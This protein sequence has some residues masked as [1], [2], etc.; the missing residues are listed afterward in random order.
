MPEPSNIGTFITQT[1]TGWNATGVTGYTPPANLSTHTG[2][3]QTLSNGQTISGYNVT[4]YINVRHDDVTIV[5][6]K[7]VQVR[8][9]TDKRRTKILFCEFGITTGMIEDTWGTT[10]IQGGDYDMRRCK[11]YGAIDQ[12]RPQWG[13]TRCWENWFGPPFSDPVGHQWPPGDPPSRAHCDPCQPHKPPGNVAYDYCLFEANKFDYFP[14]NK[15]QTYLAELNRIQGGNL[16]GDIGGWP[17]TCGTMNVEYGATRNHYFLGNHWDGNCF[18]WLMHQY[19]TDSGSEPKGMVC[20]YNIIKKRW[21]NYGKTAFVNIGG[22]KGNTAIEWGQNLNADTGTVIP[23]QYKGSPNGRVLAIKPRDQYPTVYGPGG[24]GGETGGG[25]GGGGTENP[26]I[27][28]AITSP[29]D[30]STHTS[31]TVVFLGG[32]DAAA[33]DSDANYTFFDYK[34]RYP[35]PANSALTKTAF[36]DHDRNTANTGFTFT[37]TSAG[38][39]FNDRSSVSHTV[40]GPATLVLEGIRNDGTVPSATVDVTFGEEDAPPPA[41]TEIEF[42]ASIT[43]EMEGLVEI[44]S[45]LAGI[46][47]DFVARKSELVPRNYVRVW[48]DYDTR[49]DR[50][51]VLIDGQYVYKGQEQ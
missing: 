25:G 21:P 30:G 6:C 38:T 5:A 39:T 12:T 32:A 24:G 11:L 27:Q 9:N 37:V 40:L 26:V 10:Q 2:N 34:V 47:A 20:G 18:Q 1:N 44:D 45:T 19:Q 28:L 41:A 4:G 15:G 16:T 8:I 36:L 43:A 7:G 50:K 42:A 29:E 35:D 48:F 31:G 33:G 14:F 49:N 22:S 51:V 17:A 46:P 13:I 23:C 3:L